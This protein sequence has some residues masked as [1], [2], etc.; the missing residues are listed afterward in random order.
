MQCSITRVDICVKNCKICVFIILDNIEM[1]RWD[2]YCK[3]ALTFVCSV[4]VNWYEH[5]NRYRDHGL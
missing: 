4:S 3:N 2:F 1:C 5:I